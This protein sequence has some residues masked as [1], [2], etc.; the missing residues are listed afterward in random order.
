MNLCDKNCYHR[1]LG[2]PGPGHISDECFK[3]EG[4]YIGEHSEI[5]EE[6]KLLES[7]ADMGESTM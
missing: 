7:I 6:R 4:V 3:V 1:V 5:R 2:A